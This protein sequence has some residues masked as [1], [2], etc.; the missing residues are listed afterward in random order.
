MR[1]LALFA[2][3][4]LVLLAG[5]TVR[6]NYQNIFKGFST[7]YPYGWS[8][9]EDGMRVA[10]FAP[11]GG[12]Q[13]VAMVTYS[14]ENISMENLSETMKLRVGSRSMGYTV[15]SEGERSMLVAGEPAVE[16][17]LEMVQHANGTEKWSFSKYVFFRKGERYFILFLVFSPEMQDGGT[18]GR[19][20]YYE[21]IFDGMVSDF[22][23]I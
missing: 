6:Q 8:T 3:L 23:I 9:Y 20:E 10:F 13:V 12:A 2:S 15:I 7:T 17:T 11:E 22:R 4:A 14:K 18:L 16:Q 5:C 19:K 21:R 1:K